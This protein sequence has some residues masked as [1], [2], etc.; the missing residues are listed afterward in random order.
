[1]INWPWL[2]GLWVWTGM[3]ADSEPQPEA[4]DASEPSSSSWF[5][6][7]P[8]AHRGSLKHSTLVQTHITSNTFIPQEHI[9]LIKSDS[10][11]IYN[12]AKDSISNNNAILLVFLLIKA[13]WKKVSENSTAHHRNKIHIQI[14]NS[15]FK[16][17]SFYCIFHQ[18]YSALVSIG[19]L[20][21]IPES[22]VSC[23]PQCFYGSFPV[24]VSAPSSLAR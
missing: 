6:L 7:W 3:R 10:K 19:D 23:P 14:E 24:P 22:G 5:S 15:Y 21:M 4:A 20:A 9:Q 1:M 8:P 17:Y 12:V 11:D 13:S 2:Q 18:I 16:Y